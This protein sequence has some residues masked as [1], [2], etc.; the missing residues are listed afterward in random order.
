MNHNGILKINSRGVQ[1]AKLAPGKTTKKGDSSG[2]DPSH[3]VFIALEKGYLQVNNVYSGAL[4]YNKA[5]DTISF[6]TEIS[7]I[8]F[9]NDQ[10]KQWA[11]IACWEG[12]VH[13][14]ARPGMSNGVESIKHV[15][16]PSSHK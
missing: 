12:M 6:Q 15:Q 13:F 9:F 8:L 11:G 2:M 1:F 16:A 14:V 4:I 3:L 5:P 10:S 7:D